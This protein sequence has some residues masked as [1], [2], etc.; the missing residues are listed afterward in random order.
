MRLKDFRRL[1]ADTAVTTTHFL[2]KC[3]KVPRLK[4][5]SEYEREGLTKEDMQKALAMQAEDPFKRGSMGFDD[6]NYDLYNKYIL[7]D[8]E[9]DEND[10][11]SIDLGGFVPQPAPKKCKNGLVVVL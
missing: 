11:S 3:N 4:E 1:F 10:P 9:R 8:P 2:K 6:F 7:I 5:L